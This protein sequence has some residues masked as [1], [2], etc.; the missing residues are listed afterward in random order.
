MVLLRC[1][2]THPLFT[3]FP[4]NLDRLWV[5]AVRGGQPDLGGTCGHAAD[6]SVHTHTLMLAGRLEGLS[7]AVRHPAQDTRLTLLS[8]ADAGLNVAQQIV[9]AVEIFVVIAGLQQRAGIP[10]LSGT[11]FTAATAVQD[12]AGSQRAARGV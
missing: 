6:L 11:H 12:Q 1:V 7:T 3:A 9:V 4:R 8:H 5:R 10:Q 2:V